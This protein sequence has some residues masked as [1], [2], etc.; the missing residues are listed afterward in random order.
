MGRGSRESSPDSVDSTGR[1]IRGS[2]RSRSRSRSRGRRHR[3]RDRD[4]RPRRRSSSRSRSRHR[5]R[6]RSRSRGRYYDSPSGRREH[7]DRHGGWGAGFEGLAAAPGLLPGGQWG[8]PGLAEAAVPGGLPPWRLAEDAGGLLPA[9]LVAPEWGDRQWE[10]DWG[11]DSSRSRGRSRG[12]DGDWEGERE[13]WGRRSRGS[14]AATASVFVK[15]LPDDADEADV[16]HLFAAFPNV[17]SVK[18]LRDRLSGNSRGMA[19]VDFA[20]VDDARV[21]MESEQRYDLAMGG[22]RLL[23][24]YSHG[25]PSRG[26]G[27]AGGAAAL[28]WICDMCSAVNFARRLEC[29]HCYTA[30]PANPQ[31]VTA[32]LNEPSNILKVSGLEPQASEEALYEMLAAVEPNIVDM[33]VIKD[34]YT[35][36]PRGFAFVELASIAEAGK[37]MMACNGKVLQGQ[38][39]P[40]RICYAK[41]KDRLLGAAAAAQPGEAD[42]A[43]PGAALAV[44]AIRAAAGPAAA[45]GAS[46]GRRAAAAGPLGWKPKEFDV[47]AVL[48]GSSGGGSS[49]KQKEQPAAAA[50]A[51]GDT[52]AATA[53]TQHTSAAP[54]AGTT[55]AAAPAAAAAA[56]PGPSSES[57]AAAAAAG[58]D[59]ATIQALTQAGFEYQPSSG[60]WYDA[61]SGYYYDA[62]SQLY[63][64]HSTSQWYKYD[65]ATGQYNAVGAEQQ[66]QQQ[67]QQVQQVEQQPQQPQQ[68]V[69]QQP[70]Q[71]G[72][73]Q[74]QLPQKPVAAA[75]K[76]RRAV[77]GSAPQYNREGLLAAAA[78]AKER[79][80]EQKR[81]AAAKAARERQ[82]QQQNKA[83][84]Q[85]QQ[86]LMPGKPG[87]GAL[88]GTGAA[89][90]PSTG[91]APLPAAQVVAAGSVQGVVY[92]SKWAQ[93]A[94]QQQG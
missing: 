41:A 42:A 60:Y 52:A 32:D 11:R 40:L 29:Y 49:S 19:F 64:H 88:P 37:V 47:A 63:Y 2:S 73:Q 83:A 68:Q 75:D 85:K 86:Q 59:A 65:H 44:A 66:Q 36:A 93:R 57:A 81:L 21:L 12:S 58:V 90:L 78:L 71:Q 6:S 26:G 62:K 53:A 18:V 15:G 9:A 4:Y 50:A 82:Q 89:P 13:D 28:D 91:A 54:A 43:V 48:D 33:R 30:R 22:R 3:S 77:I 74:Q 8:A 80:E 55:P 61:K 1:R 14:E 16:Q 92:K 39:T 27:D 51:A 84:Q 5:S 34:K 45:A 70:Q 24:D 72:Q 79:E 20:S 46:G 87:I 10:D 67:G 56:G 25:A 35:G 31:R 23:L 94:A 69:Q 76:R 38:R 7:H 17:Q